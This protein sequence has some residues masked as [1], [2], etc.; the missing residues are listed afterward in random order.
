MADLRQAHSP[1]LP[2]RSVS[3]QRPSPVRRGERSGWLCPITAVPF[4]KRALAESDIVTSA[5]PIMIASLTTRRPAPESSG[6]PCSGLPS[7]GTQHSGVVM[8]E[9]GA[10]RAA[11]LLDPIHRKA[12]EPLDA[13]QAVV[14][15]KRFYLERHVAVAR[16]VE[17]KRRV[18][19]QSISG[20]GVRSRN[21]SCAW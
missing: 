12:I 7:A 3:L 6:K 10:E 20:A 8:P 18:G 14:G 5:A 15:L 9:I 4:R 11:A 21:G 1:G 16:V 19:H 2:V 13:R 17:F